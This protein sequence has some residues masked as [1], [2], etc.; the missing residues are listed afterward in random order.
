MEGMVPDMARGR[1]VV[2]MVVD[3]LRREVVVVEGKR[4]AGGCAYLSE[5]VFVRERCRRRVSAGRS[6]RDVLVQQ[7]RR[8][9][10]G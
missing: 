1:P 5:S 7:H 8:P 2:A 4:E 6:G 10:N 9:Q 3:V